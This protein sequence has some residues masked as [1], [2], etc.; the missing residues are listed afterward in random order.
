MLR[1]V[2][3]VRLPGI[4]MSRA[5]MFPATAAALPARTHTLLYNSIMASVEVC[6]P[7]LLNLAACALV[8]REAE[9]SKPGAVPMKPVEYQAA[10]TATH[11][12]R[13]AHRVA[14]NG[15][16]DYTRCRFGH[17]TGVYDAQTTCRIARLGH[18]DCLLEAVRA[19]AQW[20]PGTTRVAARGGHTECMLAAVRAGA[21]WHPETTRTAARDGYTECMLEAVRAGAQWDPRTT[22][23]AAFYGYTECMLAA[24]RAGAPWHPETTHAAAR[25]GHTECMLAAVRAGATWH[26]WTT[27]AT[28][29]GGHTECMLA[30]VRAGAPWDPAT[31]QLAAWGGQLESLRAAHEHGALWHPQTTVIAGTASC[32]A[33]CRAHDPALVRDCGCPGARVRE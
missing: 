3:A 17:D 20:H 8:G 24:V 33:Y 31:T 30:A 9:V 18:T 16:K 2:V 4:Y 21:Q 29:G 27:C 7:P 22:Y 14:H 5:L 10:A 13:C 12:P 15:G 25:G 32:R 26:P 6:V 23:A 28:T 1:G 11:C 19:G